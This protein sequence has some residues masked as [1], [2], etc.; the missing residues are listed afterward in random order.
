[1]SEYTNLWRIYV[2]N[3]TSFVNVLQAKRLNIVLEENPQWV[4]VSASFV[5][6]TITQTHT[7]THPPT[8]SH[9]LIHIMLCSGRN[10]KNPPCCDSTQ[11]HPNV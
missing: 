3:Y 1:M 6:H 9:H 11:K 7:P 2:D 4:P 10:K 8:L 5:T